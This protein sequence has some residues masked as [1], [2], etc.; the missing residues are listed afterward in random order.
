MLLTLLEIIR[1]SVAHFPQIDLAQ[2]NRT[3]SYIIDEA[4]DF[5]MDTGECCMNYF[6]DDFGICRGDTNHQFFP[7]TTLPRFVVAMGL[8]LVLWMLIGIFSLIVAYVTLNKRSKYTKLMTPH[9]LHRNID[10][11]IR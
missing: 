1:S 8:V 6:K 10:D 4:K 2:L 9:V 7:T 3:I 5:L 11:H